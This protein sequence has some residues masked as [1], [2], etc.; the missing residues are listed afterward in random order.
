[1]ELIREGLIVRSGH[2]PRRG[3]EG[4]GREGKGR[5]GEGEREGGAFFACEIILISVDN[6]NCNCP[7]QRADLQ[8]YRSSAKEDWK[9]FFHNLKKKKIIHG[10]QKVT[11]L[12]FCLKDDKITPPHPLPLIQTV[13]FNQ[14]ELDTSN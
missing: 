5:E 7:G 12:G 8:K 4:K 13:T 14:L 3:G 6:G 9:K 11:T 2:K 1:M 10:L